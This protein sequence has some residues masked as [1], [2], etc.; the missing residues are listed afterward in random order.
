M[1]MRPKPLRY[2]GVTPC[3]FR[4]H[5]LLRYAHLAEEGEFTHHCLVRLDIEEH[6]H[7]SSILG[8]HDGLTGRLNVLSELRCVRAEFGHG[9]N[10]PTRLG[11]WHRISGKGTSMP[12]NVPRARRPASVPTLIDTLDEIR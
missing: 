9:L 4:G 3:H 7:T 2:C 8:D 6:S 5:L 11:L 10:I 1:Q 12:N